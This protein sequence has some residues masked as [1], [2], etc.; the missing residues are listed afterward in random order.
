[1][2]AQAGP[3][4]G[5][6]VAL[7]DQRAPQRARVHHGAST[8]QQQVVQKGREARDVGIDGPRLRIANGLACHPALAVVE[9]CTASP[10]L[11]ALGGCTPLLRRVHL[12]GSEGALRYFEGC[13]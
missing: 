9:G 4:A 3:R 1:M 2:Q 8:A 10:S 6:T 5:C 11:V 12:R 13:I 7:L